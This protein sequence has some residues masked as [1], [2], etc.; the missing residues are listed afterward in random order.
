MFKYFIT[1]S[2]ELDLI[3]CMIKFSFSFSASSQSSALSKTDTAAPY[4][5]IKIARFGAVPGPER[6]Y[7]YHLELLGKG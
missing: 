5:V 6:S 7:Y 3:I 4:D 2:K 1:T